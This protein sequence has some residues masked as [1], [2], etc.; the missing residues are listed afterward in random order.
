M[1]TYR[2]KT[3]GEFI[4]EFGEHW[5]G[6]VE[7][8]WTDDGEMDYLFNK[9]LEEVIAPESF[10]HVIEGVNFMLL[11]TKKGWNVSRDMITSLKRSPNTELINTVR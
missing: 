4:A 8:T 3:E 7:F 10:K 1:K 2:I 9:S 6:L 5:K 11:R